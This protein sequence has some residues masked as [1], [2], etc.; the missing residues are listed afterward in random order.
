[1]LATVSGI[2]SGIFGVVGLNEGGPVH[3]LGWF[4]GR[5]T[6]A[7]FPLEQDIRFQIDNSKTDPSGVD[8]EQGKF[9]SNLSPQS[10]ISNYLPFPQRQQDG[11]GSPVD[12][13]LG[14]V[15]GCNDVRKLLGQC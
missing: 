8:K 10:I 11:V 9:F 3:N 1:M 13:I 4:R 5:P 7:S 12:G 14:Q 15:T 6:P 2:A